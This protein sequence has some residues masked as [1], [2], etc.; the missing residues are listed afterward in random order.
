MWT[1]A[2]P[3]DMFLNAEAEEFYFC[4]EEAF[5]PGNSD[6]E[7]VQE[8]DDMEEQADAVAAKPEDGE[9]NVEPEEEESD[10]GTSRGRPT[11]ARQPRPI[12]IYE[13]LGQLTLKTVEDLLRLCGEPLQNQP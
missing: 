12:Y 2:K 13:Q 11:R 3:A 10:P 8:R 1:T 4:C 5:L 9:R 7:R 6:E